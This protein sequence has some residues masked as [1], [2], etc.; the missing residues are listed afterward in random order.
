MQTQTIRSIKPLGRKRT[1]DFEVAHKDHNF[2]A[3]GVVVSNSH[4]AAYSMVTA[5]TLFL[6]ANHPL[7]FYFSLLEMAS[8]EADSHAVVAQ[9]EK[10]MRARGFKLLPPHFIKSSMGFTIENDTSIRFALGLIRGIS[11]KNMER[12]QG[13]LNVTRGTTLSKFEIFQALKNAGLNIGIGCSLIQAGCMDGYE[14]Y[15]DKEGKS[16]NSRSR[17][18]LELST[19]NILTDKEKAHLM[20]LAAKP[21]VQWDVLAGIKHL[22]TLTNEKGKPLIT[23]ARLATIRKK[24]APYA[25]IYTKNSRNENLANYFYERR[26]LGYSYSQTLTEI[27][28]E[29]VDGLMSCAEILAAPKDTKCKA[30]GFVAEPLQGKTKKGNAEFKFRLL[31]ETGELRIKA[32]NDKI[33]LIKADNNGELPDEN[34]LVI[35]TGKKMS[36]DTLFVERH[37]YSGTVLGIQ[38]A[39]IYTKLSE[40][41]DDK[42]KE[43]KEIDSTT[44]SVPQPS[45]T[46]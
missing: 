21:E 11:E 43:P 46:Q 37:G 35:L 16:Y 9:I 19:F 40:L 4:S 42:T 13:F 15:V 20:G 32:F 6:K 27:F 31:D 34:D 30:I 18:T 44:P 28:G 7:V 29:H 26:V 33:D 36:E 14:N 12:I 22:S 38:S 23:E 5:Y 39:R 25:E 45:N 1:L 2:Y 10:E 8:E 17:L 41:K 24:Y 3:E